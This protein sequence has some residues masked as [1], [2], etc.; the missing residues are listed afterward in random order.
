LCG[1][2]F[3]KLCTKTVWSDSAYKKRRADGNRNL[4]FKKVKVPRKGYT[5]ILGTMY[6]LLYKFDAWGYTK[7]ALNIMEVRYNDLAKWVE[8]YST[9]EFTHLYL[10]HYWS[11]F[12]NNSY[13]P[14]RI[15]NWE[16]DEYGFLTT[17]GYRSVWHKHLRMHVDPDVLRYQDAN[18]KAIQS[19][20]TKFFY[21]YL[22][23]DL[24]DVSYAEFNEKF[25]ARLKPLPMT[26]KKLL[27]SKSDRKSFI[28]NSQKLYDERLFRNPHY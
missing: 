15:R 19:K 5:T 11:W 28:R 14:R 7:S 2:R 3:R 25:T 26:G 21:K 10:Y 27:R 1:R 16:R 18:P 20:R 17:M 22:D 23:Y 9:W 6:Y 24:I 8:N 12:W 4:R 13:I